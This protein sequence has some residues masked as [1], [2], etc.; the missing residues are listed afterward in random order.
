MTAKSGH[1][2]PI[3]WADYL[4]DTTHLSTFQHGAYLLLIAAY[5]CK[6]GPIS[7][8]MEALAH[9]CKTSKDKLARYGNPVLAMF[10][11]KGGLLYHQRIDLELSKS[12]QRIS[13]AQAK[14]HARWHPGD[15]LLTTTI[16]KEERNKTAASPRF[17]EFWLVCPRKIGRDATE[18]AWAEALKHEEAEA[19]I[20]AMRGFAGLSKD[21]PDRFI[22]SPAKWLAERRWRDENLSGSAPLDAKTAADV[23]DRADRLMRRGKYAEKYQ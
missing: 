11:S 19:I 15:M 14:A 3:Y 18:K 7:S 2:M 12:C 17:D 21:T 23:M 5:W 10:T 20:S 22:S 4:A 1:W 8:D 9:V 13:S 16:T 6:G